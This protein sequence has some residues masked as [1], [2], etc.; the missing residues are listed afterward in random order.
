M[1]RS[2]T[3]GT[4]KGVEHSLIDTVES[5]GLAIDLMIE[6]KQSTLF[7]GRISTIIYY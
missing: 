4:T 5:S 1:K 7:E 2:L 3:F 6:T